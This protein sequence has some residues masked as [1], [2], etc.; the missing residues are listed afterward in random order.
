MTINPL[1]RSDTMTREEYYRVRDAEDKQK[2][3]KKR[4]ILRSSKGSEGKD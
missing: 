1:G 3:G 4:A 2:E